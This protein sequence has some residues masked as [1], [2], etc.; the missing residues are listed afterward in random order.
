ML[1]LSRVNFKHC[2]SNRVGI[3]SKKK[4]TILYSLQENC[5]TTT[6]NSVVELGISVAILEQR[7]NGDGR[8]PLR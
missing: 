5:R 6:E 4:N 7:R 8:L 3:F 1:V 2:E